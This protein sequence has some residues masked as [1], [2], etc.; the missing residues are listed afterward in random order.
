MEYRCFYVPIVL[1]I[2]ESS[3]EVFCL[4]IF[5]FTAYAAVQKVSIKEVRSALKKG[6]FAR[7]II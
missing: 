6:L 1:F 7:L 4:I 2:L 3:L 5:Y